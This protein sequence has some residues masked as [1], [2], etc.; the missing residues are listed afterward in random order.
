[1]ESKFGRFLFHGFQCVRQSFW[2][3]NKQCNIIGI[4]EICEQISLEDGTCI[5]QLYW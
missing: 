3:V 4:V 2:F 1:M 5:C